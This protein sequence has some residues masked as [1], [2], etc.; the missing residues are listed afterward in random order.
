[1]SRICR[2]EAIGPDTRSFDRTWV[3]FTAPEGAP[4]L[5]GRLLRRLAVGF[6]VRVAQGSFPHA[7]PLEAAV[8]GATLVKV[9]GW[10][11]IRQRRPIRAAPAV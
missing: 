6:V 7:G 8:P 10:P 11:R 5:L 1:L 4:S 9:G 3:A 2:V